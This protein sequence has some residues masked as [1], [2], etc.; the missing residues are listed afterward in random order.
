MLGVLVV[1]GG[2]A[3]AWDFFMRPKPRHV[4]NLPTAGMTTQGMLDS[5]RGCVQGRDWERA[6][7]W[8]HACNVSQPRA[9]GLLL[10]ESLA[11]HNYAQGG[12]RRWAGRSASRTSLDRMELERMSAVLNDSAAAVA[13]DDAEW[14]N[15]RRW[16]GEQYEVL[17]L[18]LDAMQAYDEAMQRV[19]GFKPARD[20]MAWL[21]RMLV[22]PMNP[23]GVTAAD[24]LPRP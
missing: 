9:A 6:L 1:A 17:G 7:Q 11:W 20:R 19:P 16:R 24:A 8:A 4:S 23:R 13:R 12:S 22:D 3:L 10:N 2:V 21:Q 18:P 15:I 5:L 14:A